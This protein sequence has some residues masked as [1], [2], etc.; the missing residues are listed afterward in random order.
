M[1][2]Q[3]VRANSPI[4]GLYSTG[5]GDDFRYYVFTDSVGEEQTG[6][7]YSGSFY[8]GPGDIYLGFSVSWPDLEFN[9]SGSGGSDVGANDISEEAY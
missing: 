3:I 1:E 8:L 9:C 4:C 2:D 5:W 7:V 6:Q